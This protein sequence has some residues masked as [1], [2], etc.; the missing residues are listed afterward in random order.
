MSV[1]PRPF[2][3]PGLAA[4]ALN[5]ALAVFVRVGLSPGYMRLY[6]VPVNLISDQSRVY[7]VAPRGRTQWVRNAEAAG[8]VVLR[9][10]AHAERYRLRS[11]STAER[12]R[13]L[14]TY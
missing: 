7:L 3:A 9:R 8:E 1:S 4:R 14:K 6:A 12:P 10:G 13:I 5:R 2:E 11:L